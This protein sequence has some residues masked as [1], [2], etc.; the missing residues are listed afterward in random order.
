MG[1]SAPPPELSNYDCYD[2]KDDARQGGSDLAYN[3]WYSEEVQAWVCNQRDDCKGFVVHK[4]RGSGGWF[5]KT[6]AEDVPSLYRTNRKTCIK[7]NYGYRKADNPDTNVEGVL[8]RDQTQTRVQASGF[9]DW[10]DYSFGSGTTCCGQPGY[11]KCNDMNAYKIP[12]GFKWM[13]TNDGILNG[14]NVE[15]YWDRPDMGWT[16]QAYDLDRPNYH[17]MMDRDDCALIQN[18]GFDVE[19]NFDSMVSKNVH[20]ADALKIKANWCKKAENID[21]AKCAS[22]YATPE[23][24][25]A[26]YNYDIDK[27][28]M[29]KAD[30]N[31][32]QKASCRTAFNNAVKG[33]DQSLRQQAKDSITAYCDT[34]AG[35]NQSD[36]LCGCYNV[37]KYGGACLTSQ[38]GIP[39]CKELKA[40][41]GDLPPGAQV[42]FADKFC[43]S[44]V[45]VTQALGN[46][47]LLPDYTQGKQCPNITQCVQDF[48]NAN[49]QG[50]QVDASCKNTVSITGVAPPAPPAG[51]APAP[52]S[53][54]PAAGTPAAGTPAAGTPA[55]GTPA[56]GTPAAG[57]PAAG[58]PA[59]PEASTPIPAGKSTFVDNYINTPQKQYAFIGCCVVLCLLC[60]FMMMSGGKQ[61]GIDPMMLALMAR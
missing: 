11:P 9:R 46:A 12:L 40:T 26:G 21:K 37:M 56:A 30:P 57:T 8:P 32:F 29:C 58:T 44:D 3:P 47:A 17:G 23:A 31:W 34:D 60:M 20:P 27:F 6:N 5:K 25:A 7:K 13:I 55:A 36:G 28:Y 10:N 43:A 45:C 54:K 39:G 59:A 22:F 35:K 42:A 50:S 52:A 1:W 61:Q 2:N 53:G 18:I 19:Y 4:D 48:R 14:N 41:V 15:G 24:K 38:A 16:G 33:S 51:P 49:F